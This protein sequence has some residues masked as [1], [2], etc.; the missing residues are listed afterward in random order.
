M[1][2]ESVIQSEISQKEK[3]NVIYESIYVDSRIRYR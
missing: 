1:D 2:L 3:T